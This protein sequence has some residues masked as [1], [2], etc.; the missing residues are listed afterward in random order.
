MK[1]EFDMSDEFDKLTKLSNATIAVVR[2]S[3]WCKIG[4]H[5]LRYTSKY[6][7]TSKLR[8]VR[9]DCNAEFIEGMSGELYRY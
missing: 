3:F 9:N 6:N 4:F 7:H 8:C 2:R 1:E 5:K